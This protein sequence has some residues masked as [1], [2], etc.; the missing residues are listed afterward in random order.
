MSAEAFAT[1][2][3]TAIYNA[4]GVA[5]TLADK[6][7]EVMLFG[8]RRFAIITAHN[9]KSE[10]LSA[11]ENQRRHGELGHDLSKLGPEYGPSTG[12][13]PDRSWVEE[14]FVV[15]DIG[16]EAALELGRKFG[17]HAILWGEGERVY[18]AWCE[19]GQAEE[20]QI[21]KLP[22]YSIEADEVQFDF[23]RDYKLL[24]GWFAENNPEG[25]RYIMLQQT[26]DPEEMDSD[27]PNDNIYVERDSQKYG[28]YG[29]IVSCELYPN[30]VLFFLD[31]ETGSRLNVGSS[32]AAQLSLGQEQ[33]NDLRSGLFQI[34][35]GTQVFK[36]K[37]Q[38][39]R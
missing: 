26:T 16:L 8:R 21:K 19:T 29:G 38:I 24:V 30:R 9:P 2:Y 27:E 3:Q 7:T 6:P 25:Q 22:M 20:F 11:E 35:E 33:L 37:T 13:S 32:M 28:A 12:E 10:R 14:G 5:F 17:Q 1:A 36:D 18:L 23:D 4:A 34:F 31:K 15:F 39:G